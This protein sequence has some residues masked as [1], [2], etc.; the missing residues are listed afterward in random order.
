MIA[1]VLL[2]LY[3]VGLLGGLAMKGDDDEYNE[4]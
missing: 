3:L 1:A 4:G 2:V